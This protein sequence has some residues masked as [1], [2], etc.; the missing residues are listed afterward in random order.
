MLRIKKENIFY[1]PFKH[2]FVNNFLSEKHAYTMFENFPDFNDEIW[3]SKGKLYN[4]PYG[5]KKELT[6]ISSLHPSYHEFFSCVFEKYFLDQLSDIFEIPNIFCDEKLYGGGLNLYDSGSKLEPHIDFNYNN[7]L[8]AYRAINL[9]Y[10]LNPDWSL[11]KGGNLQFYSSAQSLYK[12]Y[13]PNLNSCVIFAS[14]N[15]TIHGVSE[16]IEGKRKS[17][18]IWYYSKELPKNVSQIPSKTKWLN[19]KEE[20]T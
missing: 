1:E 5:K 13:I 3:N 18:G 8:D 17:I 4:T 2:V 12:E 10:Y 11:K 7:N 15:K 20:E 9:L 6:D 14:N 19:L 16:I